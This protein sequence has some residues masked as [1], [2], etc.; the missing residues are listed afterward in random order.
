MPDLD[1]G[2][3]VEV[4]ALDVGLAAVGDHLPLAFAESLKENTEFQLLEIGLVGEEEIDTRYLSAATFSHST[5]F[6]TVNQCPA[7]NILA[8]ICFFYLIL[9]L[10]QS[11][12]LY[13]LSSR[14]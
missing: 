7:L 6:I 1:D 3:I 4:H 8:L 11:I 12:Y 5:S 2:G 10:T 9:S 14:S 13:F